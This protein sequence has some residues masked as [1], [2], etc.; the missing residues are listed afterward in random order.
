MEK[1]VRAV[2]KDGVLHPLE[3]LPLQDKQQVTVIISCPTVAGQEDW[4]DR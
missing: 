4:G 3:A 2:Y 1:R